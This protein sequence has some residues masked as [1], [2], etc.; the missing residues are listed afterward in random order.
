MPS[1][2]GP[3]GPTIVKSINDSAANEANDGISPAAIGTDVATCSIPALPGAQNSCSGCVAV[4]WSD[5]QSACSL[6]PEPITRIFISFDCH[7]IL[8]MFSVKKCLTQQDH[9][10]ISAAAV[11]AVFVCSPEKRQMTTDSLVF[12]LLPR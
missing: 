12:P 3:S 2:S 10:H 8:R 1:A 7:K 4:C 11:A 9:S 6:P 5:Q